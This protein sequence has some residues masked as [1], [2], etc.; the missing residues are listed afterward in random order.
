M[1]LLVVAIVSILAAVCHGAAPA[2]VYFVP[3]G[4]QGYRPNAAIQGCA[5]SNP[6]VPGQP[7]NCSEMIVPNS[8]SC[9]PF[10]FQYDAHR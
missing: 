1:K 5:W 4:L 8:I 9:F 7:N 10:Q 2:D 3:F 6:F